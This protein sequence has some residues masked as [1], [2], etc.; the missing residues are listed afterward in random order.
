MNYRL[1][2][3]Q[4]HITQPAVTLH[5]HHLEEHYGVKL[6]S[7]DGHKLVKTEEAVL[8]ERVARAMNYQEERL[9][10]ALR[11]PRAHSLS[12]G[13]TKTIGEFVAAHQIARYL[14]NPENQLSIFVD[15][16]TRVLE[17]LD[18]GELDFALV[19]GQFDRAKYGSKLYRK[20]P[21]I[22]LC[23]KDHPLAGRV[24]SVSPD[25]LWGETLL[26]REKGSGSRAILENLLGESNHSIQ[27][28]S[29]IVSVSNSGLLQQLVEEGCGIT[30]AF[31]AIARNGDLAQFGVEGMDVSREFNYV[32]HRNADAEQLV[33]LFDSYRKE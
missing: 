24:V 3:E 29:R 4:L 20:E 28:F 26:L 7:Y 22:G 13:L 21:F 15:N 10:T 2:A 5:I 11:A 33:S 14:E 31:A 32:F 1:A 25:E 23:A 8:L 6:F 17:R 27:D 16:T 19:E 9:Q 30:F 18:W 12:I